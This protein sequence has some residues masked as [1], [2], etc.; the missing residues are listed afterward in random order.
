MAEVEISWNCVKKSYQVFEFEEH[1]FIIGDSAVVID[2]H[3]WLKSGV[4]LLRAHFH[5]DYQVQSPIS[6]L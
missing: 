1:V 3:F 4:L 2:K 6:T 5:L